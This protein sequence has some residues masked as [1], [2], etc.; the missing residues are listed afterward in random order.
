MFR[1]TGSNLQRFRFLAC[2]FAAFFC[3]DRSGQLY[4]EL[5]NPVRLKYALDAVG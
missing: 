2:L 4:A 5:L 1:E 3:K